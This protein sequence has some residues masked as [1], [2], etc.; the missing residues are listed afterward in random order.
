MTDR[1]PS[2]PEQPVGLDLLRGDDVLL[3]ALGRGE[4]GPAGDGI[5]ALFAAWR[6]DLAE[7]P[8][9][10]ADDPAEDTPVA[11]VVP[12]TRARRLRRARLGVAAAVLAVVA[13]G[14]GLAAAQASPGSF[15]G[16]NWPV[17]RRTS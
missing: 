13:G 12:I 15:F 17:K 14:T 1:R 10:A 3:D 16:G 11:E 9:V 2:A 6:A 4:P 5:A 7:T 8:A